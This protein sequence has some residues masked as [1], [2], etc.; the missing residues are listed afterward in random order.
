MRKKIIG[1]VAFTAFAGLLT[2]G[3][4]SEVEAKKPPFCKN[5]VESGNKFGGI[6]YGSGPEC[7][8]CKL[9]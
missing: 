7:Y 9:F 4:N 3:F 8:R 1:A 2:F 5:G 6:C